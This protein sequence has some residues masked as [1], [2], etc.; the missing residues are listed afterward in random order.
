MLRDFRVLLQFMNNVYVMLLHANN[1]DNNM[2]MQLIL[3]RFLWAH[4]KS[5]VTV[6]G[7]HSISKPHWLK[8]A[9][10]EVVM[11]SLLIH[12]PNPMNKVAIIITSSQGLAV[13]VS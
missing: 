2:L 6:P 10:N 7:V 5:T 11:N 13:L 1:G 4:T 8:C 12:D 9:Y 3:R